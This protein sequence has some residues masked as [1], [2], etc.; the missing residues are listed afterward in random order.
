VLKWLAF[1][2]LAVAAYWLLVTSTTWRVFRRDL[3]SRRRRRVER[4]W[5]I[6]PPATVNE[7]HALDH[8]VRVTLRSPGT[9]ANNYALKT[10]GFATPFG[11]A[12]YC[13]VTRSATKQTWTR[14]VTLEAWGQQLAFPADFCPDEMPYPFF[15]RYRVRWV[16]PDRDLV[17]HR[18]FWI[19]EYGE[20]E[21]A[22]IR[23]GWVRVRERCRKAWFHY[24]DRDAEYWQTRLDV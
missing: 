15:G 5:R 1:S 12:A 23:R 20:P 9:M 16:V 21:L 8:D 24:R 19:G 22:P 17:R 18:T 6:E 2:T 13:T 4:Q 10:A 3:R 14:P 7:S 11:V